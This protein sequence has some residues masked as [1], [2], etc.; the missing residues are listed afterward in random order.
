MSETSLPVSTAASPKTAI[1]VGDVQYDIDLSKIPYLSSFVNFQKSTQP[2]STVFV[3]GPIPLFDIALKGI[4]SGFRKCFRLLPVDLSQYYALCETCDF[5]CADV[6]GGHSMD[7]IIKDLKVCNYDYEHEI[8]GD[9]AKARDT[10]FMFLYFLLLREFGE[11]QKES[12]KVFNAVLFVVTHP[13]TFKS[14]ARTVVRAAYE[15]RF[16]ISQKQRARLDHRKK[17][18]D[19]MDDDED[20]TTEEEDDYGDEYD[21]DY[22]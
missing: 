16:D 10:A 2:V 15:E 11:G 13:G 21:F 9:K 8:K 12:A 19:T 7:E 3:H 1:K 6:L 5:L 4:E 14:K 20:V 17:E 18:E 22:W